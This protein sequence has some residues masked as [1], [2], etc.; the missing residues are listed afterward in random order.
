MLNLFSSIDCALVTGYLLPNEINRTV[1]WP[2]FPQDLQRSL[3]ALVRPNITLDEARRALWKAAEGKTGNAGVESSITR[4]TASVLIG[5]QYIQYKRGSISVDELLSCSSR[6]A[7]G[8]VCDIEP[9]PF[10]R[11]REA[12]RRSDEALTD[13]PNLFAIHIAQATETM[14]HW[15]L[16]LSYSIDK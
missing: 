12:I 7:D 2:A 9:T 6:I 14:K 5:L 8:Y 15:G 4:D 1:G 11:L 10:L 13:L 3:E 16:I